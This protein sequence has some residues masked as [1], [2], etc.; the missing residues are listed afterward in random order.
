MLIVVVTSCRSGEGAARIRTVTTFLQWSLIGK[1]GN[2]RCAWRKPS[3]RAI[4]TG[5]LKWLST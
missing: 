5:R 1:K 3:S 2:F 4:P